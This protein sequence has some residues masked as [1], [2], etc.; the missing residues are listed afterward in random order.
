MKE[1][2][3]KQSMARTDAGKAE[4]KKAMER[5]GL[6]WEQY[7]V[8]QAEMLGTDVQNGLGMGTETAKRLDN[9]LTRCKL[10]DSTPPTAAWALDEGESFC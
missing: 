8:E 7:V 9:F 4:L 2:T 10:I 1:K 6:E 3:K 5:R